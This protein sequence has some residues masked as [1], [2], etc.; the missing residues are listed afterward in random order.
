MVGSAVVK[1]FYKIGRLTLSF[2]NSIL[3]WGEPSDIANAVAVGILTTVAV[4]IGFVILWGAYAG[5][6][7]T[8]DWLF[9][10]AAVEKA[11][12]T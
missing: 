1:V 6:R 8:S 4:F 7:E 10:S 5:I 2:W 3:G 9:N 11:T 12:S